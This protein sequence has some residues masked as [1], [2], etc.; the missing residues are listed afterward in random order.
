[1]S[2]GIQKKRQE[3]DI[4]QNGNHRTGVYKDVD[5]EMIRPDNTYWCGYVKLHGRTKTFS[6][7]QLEEL[8]EV[9]HGGFTA[10]FGFDCA[11]AGDYYFEEGSPFSVFFRQTDT[12]KDF[13]YVLKNIKDIIDQFYKI[14]IK[15]L[16]DYRD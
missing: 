4:K 14:K 12:Y 5:W 7:K 16:D 1:M 11:H 10:P 3:E 9:A 6:E 13:D 2:L 15:N 8:S